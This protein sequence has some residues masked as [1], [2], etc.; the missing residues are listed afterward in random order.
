M[1][2]SDEMKRL[3]MEGRNAIDLADQARI[4]GIWDIRQAGINKVKN[5][6]TSIEELNRITQE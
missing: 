1:E 6:F 3:V 2:I 4:E 5:G